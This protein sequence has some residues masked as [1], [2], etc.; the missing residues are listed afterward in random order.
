[1]LAEELVGEPLYEAPSTDG[2]PSERTLRV[3]LLR[4]LVRQPEPSGSWMTLPPR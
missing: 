1:M 2:S 3:C 4:Q